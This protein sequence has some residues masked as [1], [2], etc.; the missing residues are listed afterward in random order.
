MPCNF[1]DWLLSY[2][3]CPLSTSIVEEQGNKRNDFHS[4]VASGMLR[5]TVTYGK[6]STEASFATWLRGEKQFLGSH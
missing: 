2:V 5:C 6:A 4:S 1:I 3:V